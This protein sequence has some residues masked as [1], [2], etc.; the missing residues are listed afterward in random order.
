MFVYS[1]IYNSNETNICSTGDAKTFQ[2]LHTFVG[3]RKGVKNYNGHTD[4]VLCLAI[5]HDGQY[6]ASGGKDKVINIWSVKEDKHIV[7]FTQHRDCVSVC[8][9]VKACSLSSHNIFIRD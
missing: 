2:K 9:N 3:G 4:H 5:S 6:L 8:S 7:K 1:T